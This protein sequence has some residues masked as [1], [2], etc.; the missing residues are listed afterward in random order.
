MD[1]KITIE[2]N[3]CEIQK[4]ND[5]VCDLIEGNNIP[6][7]ISYSLSLILEEVLSNIINYA[8]E[9]SQKH[10]IDIFIQVESEYIEV[11]ITDDGKKF[12]FSEK[13]DKIVAD[14]KSNLEEDISKKKIGGLGLFFIEKY[15]DE[16]EYYRLGDK[17]KTRFKIYINN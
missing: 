7:K 5:M 17:N 16:L 1:Y 6:P 13:S 2:N 15:S 8:F 11:L 14:Y 12:D 9:D 4:L 3:I 10:S